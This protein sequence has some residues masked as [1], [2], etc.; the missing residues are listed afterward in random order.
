[1]LQRKKLRVRTECVTHT[2]FVS[3]PLQV[4]PNVCC[5]AQEHGWGVGFHA[6]P[7]SWRLDLTAFAYGG[8]NQVIDSETGYSGRTDVCLACKLCIPILCQLFQDIELTWSLV[9]TSSAIYS[10]GRYSFSSRKRRAVDTC[11]ARSDCVTQKPDLL[12]LEDGKQYDISQLDD[13]LLKP[14]IEFA[15]NGTTT[16][17]IPAVY[18]SL[19]IAD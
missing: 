14:L 15:F 12:A 1:M 18:E 6:I 10:G 5:Y 7:T 11:A 19:A 16:D 17:G 2:D 8:C 4:N 3:T 13:S 9:V